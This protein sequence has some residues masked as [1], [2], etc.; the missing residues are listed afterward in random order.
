M[1]AL[2]GTA[3]LSSVYERPAS[4]LALV[5]LVTP[6]LCA[7]LLAKFGLPGFAERGIGIA[8][9]VMMGM[10]ALGGF[11]RCVTIDAQRLGLYCLMV[12]TLTLPQLLRGE[13]FS[14]TSLLML[15]AVHLPYVLEVERG[16]ELTQNVLRFFLAIALLLAGCAIAQ[17]FLQG[18]VPLAFLFPIDNLVPHEF[19]V[20]GFNAQSPIRYG[21]SIYRAT[22]MFMLE[23]SFLT[24]CLAI[25][26]VAEALLFRRLWRIGVY[27][28]GIV[29][30]HAGTGILILLIC[31]PIVI[32]MRRRWDLL[33]AIGVL[34]VVLFLAA[35]L[36]HLETIASRADELS[37]PKSSGFARFVGG[38]YLFEQML[39]PQPLRALF[40]YG[41]GAFMD[42]AYLFEREVA[43]MPLTKMVFEFGVVGAAVYFGFLA[44]C[45]MVSTLPWPL[46]L[47]IGL[48]FL[49]NGM[50][51]P[52]SHAL[53]LSLLV[54]TSGSRW[55]AVPGHSRR[56]PEVA[57]DP[58]SIERNA[59]RSK[60]YF[61]QPR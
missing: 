32:V 26:I 44:R 22:G 27:G 21:S 39:W 43:D 13:E 23:P 9:P 41:A 8:L 42:Y 51:V 58:S 2:A 30:A 52:F 47:A 18:R 40:G 49:L 28:L 35:D 25:A 4:R 45:L 48:T 31:L 6:I 37:D 3:S 33:L 1:S 10:F 56:E 19:V 38:F 20:Q 59:W 15:A 29:V 12:A 54:L 5:I 16:H 11:A 7:T 55:S 60:P 46:A 24:Q 61:W 36:L 50:Y 14:T 17:Y 34:A 57:P 53:A